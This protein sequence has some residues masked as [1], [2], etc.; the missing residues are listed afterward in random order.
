VRRKQPIRRCM[1][2]LIALMLTLSGGLC[3]PATAAGY[4]G[5]IWI[6]IN[7]F[8]TKTPPSADCVKSSIPAKNQARAT[9]LL[10]WLGFAPLVIKAGASF[11]KTAFLNEVFN[12][13]AVYVHTH[14]DK[15]GIQAMFRADPGVTTNCVKGS[16]IYGTEIAARTQGTLYNLVMIS[17]CKLGAPDSWNNMPTAFNI[18]KTNF[19]NE[20]ATHPLSTDPEWYL[21]YRYYTWNTMSAAFEDNLV[22]YLYANPKYSVTFYYAFTDAW[23][24]RKYDSYDTGSASYPFTPMWYGNPYYNGVPS[25]Q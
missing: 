12:D 8:Q 19:G 11:T 22:A 14:A 16:P 7:Q 23:N 3:L 9:T 4:T 2:I 18:P 21:G 6:N 25:A 10:Q 17:T 15:S 20:D 1:P 5:S 24:A 13:Y